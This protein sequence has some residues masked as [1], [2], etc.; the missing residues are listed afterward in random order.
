MK[1]AD[2][3]NNHGSKFPLGL[4]I[5]ACSQLVTWQEGWYMEKQTIIIEGATTRRQLKVLM[6]AL[7]RLRQAPE[8]RQEKIHPISNAIRNNSYRIDCRK[9]ADCLITSLMFGLLR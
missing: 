2:T 1:Q 5:E 7:R 8:V 4:P 6:K 3:I 9:L